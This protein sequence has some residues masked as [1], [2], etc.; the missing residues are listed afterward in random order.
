MSL[1]SRFLRRNAKEMQTDFRMWFLQRV[2][3]PLLEEPFEFLIASLCLAT[4]VPGLGGF[5]DTEPVT[6]ARTIQAVLPRWA[7]LSW[8]ALLTIAG[9]LIVVGMLQTSHRRTALRRKKGRIIERLG[10]QVLAYT[11]LVYSACIIYFIGLQPSA[12]SLGILFA[13]ALAAMLRAYFIKTTD[14]LV[15][16]VLKAWDDTPPKG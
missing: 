2:P 7:A 14:V 8:S 10:L 11:M 5:V 4:G 6:G 13:V 12:R 16:K 3:T 9:L 15:A 1:L